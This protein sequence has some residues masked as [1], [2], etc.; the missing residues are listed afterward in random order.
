MAKM[1]HK[2]EGRIFFPWEVRGGLRRFLALGRVGPLVLVGLASSFVYFTLGRERLAAGQ[3]QTRVG[4]DLL[5]PALV[6]YLAEH[7]GACPAK[8]EEVLPFL[9]RPELPK[10]GW[11]RPFR[12]VCPTEVP[13][14]PFI[15]M[16]DGPDGL[17]GGL[18]RI[19]N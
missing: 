18:D 13:F 19:E 1:G 6:R 10:D 8:L 5:R 17:P 2:G 9:R 4:L 12:L 16:S 15:L 7:E 3:R 14:V 11:G